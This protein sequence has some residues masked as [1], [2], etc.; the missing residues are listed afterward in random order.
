VQYLVSHWALI[1]KGRATW[2][3]RG[4][5]H[6]QLVQGLALQ[7]SHRTR[8]RIATAA[9]AYLPYASTL[10][11]ILRVGVERGPCEFADCIRAAMEEI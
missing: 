5:L 3:Q 2:K 8:S 6:W 9:S 7:S 11:S 1:V 4:G 10:G